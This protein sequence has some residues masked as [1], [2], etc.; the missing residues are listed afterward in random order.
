M[1]INDKHPEL[2]TKKLNDFLG[3]SKNILKIAYILIVILGI[4]A[5][6][7]LIKEWR[8]AEF[9]LVILKVMSPLFVGIFVAWLFDPIV[10]KLKK[11]GINRVLGS[12]ITY[13]ILI[14]GILLVIGSI[15]PLLSEQ[16]NE[17]SKTIPAVFETIKSWI[18]G[19]FNSLASIQNFNGDEAKVEVFAQIEKFADGLTNDLPILT[20]NFLTSFFSGLGIIL[21]G[22]TFGF[23][24][25]ISFDGVND[26][27]LQ[28]LPLRLRKDTKKLIHEVDT[29]LRRF[30]TGALIDS[31]F[32]FILMSILLWMI[33][34]KSPLL[35]AL[36]IG[37]TNVIPYAGPFIGGAPAVIFA[38]SQS[39]A[40][41]FLTLATVVIVQFLEGNFIQP[42]IMSKS[43]RLHPVTIMMGLL[44]FGYFFGIMGMFVST[45]IIAALKSIFIFF[46]D[47]YDLLN[48]YK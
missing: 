36:F 29:S 21:I 5:V 13:V 37:L 7:L 4:Y 27:L 3:L 41:G 11:M 25:L 47:K 45:P 40:I 20:V 14:G 17:L 31:T 46:N 16:L 32:M 24:L 26:S 6:T 2:D 1:A 38:F 39:T 23:Y 22:L 44:I 18:D 43:T 10:T 42:I 9:L 48:F 30:V 15:I 33:G 8:I 28:V 19:I 12:I 35:F 34:V